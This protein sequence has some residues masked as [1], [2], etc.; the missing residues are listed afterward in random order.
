M[1]EWPLAFLIALSS[2]V[3]QFY[4]NRKHLEVRDWVVLIILYGMVFLGITICAF[5]VASPVPQIIAWVTP[6]TEGIYRLLGGSAG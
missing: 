4:Y 5:D 2:A 6:I 3:I 1:P